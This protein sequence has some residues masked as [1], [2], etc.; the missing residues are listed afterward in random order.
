MLEHEPS[1][2]HGPP[3]RPHAGDRGHGRF[4]DQMAEERCL[5]QN[6]DIQEPRPRLERDGREFLPPMNLAGGVRVEH[7]RGEDDP[8]RPCRD[9]SPGRA[10]ARCRAAAKDMVRPIDRLKERI[11]MGPGPG[12]ARGRDQDQRLLGGLKGSPKGITHRGDGQGEPQ[13]DRAPV[14]SDQV[15]QGMAGRVLSRVQADKLHHQNAGTRPRIA[16]KVEFKRVVEDRAQVE[17]RSQMRSARQ[18]AVDFGSI[19]VPESP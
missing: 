7:R 17:E 11:E 4:V 14:P 8:A 12:L 16:L 18:K 9:P 19:G 2:P 5:G 1:V 3:A 15:G 10:Q 13:L 6:L